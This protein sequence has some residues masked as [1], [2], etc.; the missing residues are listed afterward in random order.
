MESWWQQLTTLNQAFYVQALFFSL[1][2]LWQLAGM[3]FGIDGDGHGDGW[4]MPTHDAPSDGTHGDDFATGQVVFS[5]LSIRSIVA[6]GT[7]FSW[8]GALY[9]SGGTAPAWAV[10]Y[11]LLWGLAGMFLVSFLMYGL[12]RLQETERASL[13]HVVG[14]E[15][16]VYMNVPKNG[17][18]KVRVLVRGTISFVSARAAHGEPLAAGTRVRVVDVVDEKTVSVTPIGD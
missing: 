11:S 7:L 18:G 3:L 1:L 17:E 4:H 15:A 10:A 2:F 8:A 14:E 9:L 6:F 12:L 16:T 13:W 5:L